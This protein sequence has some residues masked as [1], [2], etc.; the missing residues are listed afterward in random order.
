MGRVC[1]R[2]EEGPARMSDAD[3]AEFDS[4]DAGA[5]DCIPKQAGEIRKGSYAMLKGFPCKVVDY[6]TSKTGKHGHAKAHIIGIDIFTGKKHEDLC[7]TSHNMSVPKETKKTFEA[8]KGLIVTVM[9]A[10][11][12]E[13]VCAV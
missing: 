1:K 7:P 10:V 12:Q 11:G 5:A 3:D 2:V 4:A 8:G 6:S 13:Q 9:A